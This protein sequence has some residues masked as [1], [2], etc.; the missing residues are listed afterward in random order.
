MLSNGPGRYDS[1]QD[2]LNMLLQLDRN[3]LLGFR[4]LGVDASIHPETKAS[5][6]FS[7]HNG[8]LERCTFSSWLIRNQGNVNMHWCMFSEMRWK[9]QLPLRPSNFS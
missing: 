4:R 6:Q 9:D 7:Y 3:G 2:V 1:I 8:T 5:C